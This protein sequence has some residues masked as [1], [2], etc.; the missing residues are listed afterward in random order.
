MEVGTA[1][2]ATPV[3]VETATAAAARW[4]SLMS[5]SCT[6][7]ML[8]LEDLCYHPSSLEGAQELL[9][10]IEQMR[11]ECEVLKDREKS[12]VKKIA[13]LLG[14][15]MDYKAN[16]DKMLLESQKW[17]GYQVRLSTL[18]SKIASLEAEKVKLECDD[19][20]K[21]VAKLVSSFIFNGRCQ[22]FEEA[23][24]MKEPFDLTKV[25]GYMPSYKHEHTKVGN[26]F[27]IATFPYLADVV[28]DPY[29]SVEALLSKKPWILQRLVPTRTHVFAS[30]TPSQKATPSSVPASQPMS[31]PSQVTPATAS[32]T[33]L[34]SPP[35]A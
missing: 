31:P 30:S 14:E 28:A 13:T 27:M 33:K 19:M 10:V 1:A 18:E 26:E 6:M 7:P 29:A 15:V 5:L 24:N 12:F 11:G 23:A 2:A 22:A 17:A 20:G 4:V 16:L 32:F 9:K 35:P 3:E 21:L 25:K 34:Q 8:S